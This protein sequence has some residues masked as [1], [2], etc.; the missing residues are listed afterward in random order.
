MRAFDPVI[1]GT[2]HQIIEAV[3]SLPAEQQ[4]RAIGAA[5]LMHG[6]YDE[7]IRF[8]NLARQ[9][10]KDTADEAAALAAQ[11]QGSTTETNQEGKER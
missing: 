11:V 1:S 5:A 2:V 4:F 9:A 8:A 10:A 6:Q 7:A 3:A